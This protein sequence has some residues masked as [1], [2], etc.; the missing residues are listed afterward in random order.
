MDD[1]R[2]IELLFARDEQALREIE[3]KYGG[4]CRY[5]AS[6][7][8]AMN[9]DVEE[10]C[11]D[12]LLAIWNAI[13]PEVPKDLK[14]YLTRAVRNRARD[15]SRE[16]NAWK[17]G[18]RVQIV[19][20][21]F[22]SLLD[23]GTDLA[24]DFEAK[25]AGEIISRVLESIPEADKKIFVLRYWL[26][27]SIEQIMHQMNCGESRVKVSLHRTRKKIADELGKRGITV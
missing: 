21:E 7:V 25:R 13:P 26:G 2:I 23:D 16:T 12:I 3:E 20:D 10:C 8:L 6:N 15:I 24:S 18:G 14:A 4:L 11:N 1:K 5:I 19:G 9:E 27:M 22:L 17:R